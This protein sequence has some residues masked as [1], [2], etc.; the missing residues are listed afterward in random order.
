MIHRRP[1]T[2]IGVA[3]LQFGAHA[4]LFQMHTGD[5][6][7]VL[8]DSLVQRDHP[9]PV[10]GGEARAGRARARWCSDRGYGRTPAGRRRSRGSAR[11]RPG[12]PRCSSAG[13]AP[14]RRPR[15]TPARSDRRGSAACPRR[16]DYRSRRAPAPRGSAYRSSSRIAPGG[17]T[18]GGAGA[19]RGSVPSPCPRPRAPHAP[20]HRRGG[21]PPI[22]AGARRS[23]CPL[24]PR[25]RRRHCPPA[26]LAPVQRDRRPY[27]PPRR[28]LHVRRLV[29]AF[30][31]V[32]LSVL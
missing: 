3:Q 11:S 31:P 5:D 19:R 4:H 2:P 18:A 13:A 22:V 25:S 24:A 32:S 15:R 10:I 30:A 26:S 9:T 29:T 21:S 28:L 14:S 12:A 16:A 1:P 8:V 27:P 6:Q 20:R 23:S 17:R 7:V